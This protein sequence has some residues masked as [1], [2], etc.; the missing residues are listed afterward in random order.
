[1]S[2]AAAYTKPGPDLALVLFNATFNV[3]PAAIG[4]HDVVLQTLASPV[5]PSDVLQVDGLYPLPPTYQKLGN[6]PAEAEVAVGGNEGLFRVSAVGC[7]VKNYVVGDWVIPKLPS[8]GTWRTHALVTLMKD[9]KNPD[10]LIKV[11]NEADPAPLALLQAA[12]ISINPCTAYQLIHNYVK[13]WSADGTDWIISNAGNSQVNKF[14]VQIAKHKGINT[15]LVIRGGKTNQKAVEDELYGL[16]ATKVL[17][18]TELLREGFVQNTLPKLIGEKGRVRLALN[19]VGGPGVAPLVASLSH[20]GIMATYG[21][22]SNLPMTYSAS[23]QLFK[24]LTTVS[25]WLTRNTRA[26][27]QSKVDTV[28]EVVK[29]FKK[30]ALKEVPF[31]TV[32]FKTRGNGDLA[33]VLLAAIEASSGDKQVIVYK[34]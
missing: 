1:M 29:L 30:G 17:T 6:G 19:S 34:L 13:D 25:Y 12:T 4:P 26:D 2:H 3:D 28:E 8:F 10:P 27:P 18:D 15:I 9:A 21:N 33:K 31:K 5:N 11:L 23:D 7:S 20:G 16:G 24:D 32:E 22:S 14:V